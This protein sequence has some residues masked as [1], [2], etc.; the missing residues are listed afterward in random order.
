MG[1]SKAAIALEVKVNALKEVAD[2]GDAIATSL[3]GLEFVVDAFD[4]AATEAVNEVVG[5]LIEPIGEGG[6]KG[7]ETLQVRAKGLGVPLFEPIDTLIP[8][9]T[10]F[11]NGGQFF[12]ES[13]GQLEIEKSFSIQYHKI[14]SMKLN[15]FL[16]KTRLDFLGHWF[17]CCGKK[18]W[19]VG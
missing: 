14:G 1:L 10:L 3:E 7:I 12:S 8:R 2:V 13:V 18:K 16:V 5:N 9:E 6:K 15:R 17:V 19:S 11:K 4:K